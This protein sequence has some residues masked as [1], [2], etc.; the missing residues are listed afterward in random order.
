MEITLE[1]THV[2]MAGCTVPDT[3]PIIPQG[4]A[5]IYTT[6]G[7]PANGNSNF[8]NSMDPS[9]DIAGD[10]I[11]A[12]DA[13]NVVCP[14]LVD[15]QNY[16]KLARGFTIGDTGAGAAG[17]CTTGTAGS[18]YQTAAIPNAGAIAADTVSFTLSNIAF[19]IT[20]FE[21][22]DS[23]YYD[24]LNHALDSGHE[25]NIYFKNYIKTI[26]NIHTS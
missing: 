20:R 23:S 11:T 16:L 26:F 6:S 13:L 22:G 7:A 19:T 9:N 5:T 21:F 14:K 15:V 10:V 8:I 2:L 1:G 12:A 24:A 4:G 3:W 25:F 17:N 18:N